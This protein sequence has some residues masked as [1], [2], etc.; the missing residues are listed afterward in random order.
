MGRAL[1][2]HPYCCQPSHP[3]PERADDREGDG[4]ESPPGRDPGATARENQW[5]A[6]V[7]RR[8]DQDGPGVGAAQGESGT[9]RVSRATAATGH[10][11]HTARLAH[12]R[13]DRQ[14]LGKAVAQLGATLGR[15]FSYGVLQAVSP[16]DEV[17]L[18]QGLEQFVEAEILY[19]RGLP[20]QAPVLLQACA[21]PGSGVS[22]IAA[23]HPAAV[24]PRIAQVLEERFPETR[25]D[26]ARMLA[27]HYTEAGLQ[28]P[29]VMYWQRAG[30]RALE[31]SA[32]VEAIAHLRQGLAL[33]ATLP[34]TPERLAA[35]A[36]AVYGSG[37]DISG[38]PGL[39]RP[40]SGARLPPGTRVLPEGRRPST[41]LYSAAWLV[42]G[43]SCA[44]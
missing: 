20:P 36:H 4:R 27:H 6:T 9:L 40:R 24:P 12:G 21:D 30:Q 13:L 28:A 44:C 3:C 38:Y 32:Y 1:A 37:C 34:D 26:A 2:Y 8:A 43:V 7:R 19:Q 35:R 5:R 33:T 42:V 14:G 29:A 39:C 23:E 16:L 10:S 15:E 17:T 18:Q 25:R 22:V 31:R 41:A 11:H